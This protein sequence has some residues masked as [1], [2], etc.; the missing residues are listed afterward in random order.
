M[1]CHE[2]RREG[3]SITANDDLLRQCNY[4]RCQGAVY[5]DTLTTNNSTQHNCSRKSISSFI[6]AIEIS[7]RSREKLMEKGCSWSNLRALPRD[8]LSCKI[9]LA[10]FHR[11][12]CLACF[13]YVLLSMSSRRATRRDTTFV[14]GMYN[15]SSNNRVIIKSVKTIKKKV[16]QYLIVSMRK[17]P[18]F[19]LHLHPPL[20][21]SP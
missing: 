18:K 5:S 8:P 6:D 7:R 1:R 19:S 21:T 4:C 10:L 11:R 16:K 14:T 9:N 15:W 17:I 13:T 12:L 2:V 20:F 3:C